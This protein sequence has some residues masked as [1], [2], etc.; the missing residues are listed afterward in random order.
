MTTNIEI[1]RRVSESPCKMNSL[2]DTEEFEP[3]EKNKMIVNS[4]KKMRMLL[5]NRVIQANGFFAGK[6]L[7]LQ[8]Q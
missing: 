2:V 7:I 3:L 4:D 5:K 6:L 8:T 1:D